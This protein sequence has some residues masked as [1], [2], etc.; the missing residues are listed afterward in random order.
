[1]CD[2]P[3]NTYPSRIELVPEC[4][5]TQKI[6]DKAVNKWLFVFNWIPDEYKT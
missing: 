1:M 6:C 3:V 5:K 2:K 4:N